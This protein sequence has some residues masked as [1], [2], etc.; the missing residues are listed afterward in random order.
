MQ[1]EFDWT[2]AERQGWI[3][4]AQLPTGEGKDGRP[5][6]PIVMKALL[7]RINHRMGESSWCYQSQATLARDMS[8][9]TKT[10][11]RASEALV[12]LGL[13]ILIEQKNPHG[14]VTN[15]YRIVWSELQ[16]YEPGRREEWRR[17]LRNNRRPA[18]SS[19]GY[20]S[21]TSD[22]RSDTSDDRSD[23]VSTKLTKKLTRE[24]T[25]TTTAPP[26]AGT[27]VLPE[28]W[29]V[30]VVSLRELGVSADDV[31]VVSMIRSAERRG[32]SPDA[33]KELVQRY[34]ELP[35]PR[36]QPGWLWNWLAKPGSA[37]SLQRSPA[38][39]PPRRP[40]NAELVRTRA[41]E[42]IT[43]SIRDGQSGRPL[44]DAQLEDRDA[45]V[46]AAVD[47]ARAEWE[48]GQSLA[49]QSTTVRSA[50]ENAAVR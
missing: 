44:S 8:C 21:D 38:E 12:K 4:E 7:N 5:V 15:H 19:E 18:T 29:Q 49:R 27:A 37:P 23:T 26:E 46:A 3:N 1:T 47:R 6:S 40:F 50:L 33:A 36:K 48:A 11:Q 42:A 45:R 13:L 9:S 43:R 31:H 25:T 14:L 32:L 41:Y 30:V 22:D 28:P 2:R 24:R 16:M 17:L 39:E 35:D 20:R 34:R 10:I